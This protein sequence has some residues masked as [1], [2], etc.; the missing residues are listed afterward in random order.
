[1]WGNLTPLAPLPCE[2]RGELEFLPPLFVKGKGELESLLFVKGWGELE[3]LVPPLFVKGKGEQEFLLP[4]WFVKG[5]GELDSPLLVGEGLGERSNISWRWDY[6][7]YLMWQRLVLQPV[8][9]RVVG[10]NSDTP[11]NRKAG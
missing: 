9:G 2:G 11:P 10:R 7:L 1:M 8:G 5:W 6:P 4:P 3:Y